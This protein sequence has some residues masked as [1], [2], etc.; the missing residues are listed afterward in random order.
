MNAS[1]CIF[2]TSHDEL[3]VLNAC[4]LSLGPVPQAHLTPKSFSTQKC[5]IV[6]SDF[7]VISTI[8]QT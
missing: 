1:A 5:N 8:C 4:L 2:P 3:K 7:H 6:T